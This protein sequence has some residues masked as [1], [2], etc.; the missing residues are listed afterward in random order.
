M[1]H[2]KNLPGGGPGRYPQKAAKEILLLL[3]NIASNAE[4]KGLGTENLKLTHIQAQRG[5]TRKRRKPKGR[6]KLW[7]T[8]LVHVQA[9]CE[10]K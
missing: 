8:Q 6:W 10:E 9:V 5:I 4:Y 2:R 7:R 3:K 1:G